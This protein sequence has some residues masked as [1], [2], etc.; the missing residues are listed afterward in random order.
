MPQEVYE[1]KIGDRVK[2]IFGDYNGLIGTIVKI[3]E[4]AISAAS[5]HISLD[6]P[7]SLMKRNCHIN[8]VVF[9]STES[10]EKLPDNLQFCRE[11]KI[12][13]IVR[14]YGIQTLSSITYNNKPAKVLP[15]NSINSIEFL[16]NSQKWRVFKFTFGYGWTRCSIFNGGVVLEKYQPNSW[17]EIKAGQNIHLKTEFMSDFYTGTCIYSDAAY[18]IIKR[19]NLGPR[20]LLRSSI[21]LCDVWILNIIDTETQPVPI[22]EV[23]EPQESGE[24]LIG[25]EFETIKI[26]SV[27]SD[28]LKSKLNT[29]SDDS[30]RGQALEFTLKEPQPPQKALMILHEFL[31]EAKPEVDKSCGFHVHIS[32][33]PWKNKSRTANTV[34]AIGALLE[35]QIFPLVPESRLH[36]RY[37][38]P[39]L[40]KFKT[41][42]ELNESTQKL[43]GVVHSIKLNNDKRFAWIN[44]VELFRPSGINTI[45]FRLM[46]NSKRFLYLSGW[47]ILCLKIIH[48]ATK[49][50]LNEPLKYFKAIDELNK[51]IDILFKARPNSGVAYGNEL[52]SLLF[53]NISNPSSDFKTLLESI[54]EGNIMEEV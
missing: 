32:Q 12:N 47:L 27:L 11:L 33:N 31:K 2:C 7:R 14:V 35:K 24:F 5:Y 6:E 19:E 48:V 13:S 41:L 43:L 49:L 50:S 23:I 40:E 20:K 26:N 9:G 16:H 28:S 15:F 53:K 52:K 38:L 29:L 21:L 46:G 45:E 22:I 34:L 1:L 18:L 30:V 25:W 37:C 3:E 17:E 8:C 54:Q 10:F 4:G 44:F 36:N 51:Y 42:G 39:L